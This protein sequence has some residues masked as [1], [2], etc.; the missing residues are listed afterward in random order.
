MLVVRVVSPARMDRAR[1]E[2]MREGNYASPVN[3][4]ILASVAEA[5]RPV[6]AIVF[7]ADSPDWG[8]TDDLTEEEVGELGYHMIRSQLNLYRRAARAGVRVVVGVGFGPREVDGYTRGGD[9]MVE[10]LERTLQDRSAA[11][12]SASQLDLWL[13][14]HLTLWTTASLDE[15]LDHR[16]AEVIGSADRGRRKLERLLAALPA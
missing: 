11:D 3:D 10:E 14:D 1:L 15:F 7:D 2:R 4:E 8:F 9:R 5:G 12:S 13:I 16:V 6:A